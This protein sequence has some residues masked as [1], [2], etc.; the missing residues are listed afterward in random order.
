MMT[1]ATRM[2]QAPM[3]MEYYMFES[4]KFIDQQF[5]EGYAK[6][7][8][9]LLAAFIT[10]SATDFVGGMLHNTLENVLEN[11]MDNRGLEV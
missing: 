6:E 4:I 10:G 3:T 11:M 5:G 8:P 9:V 7:N 1:P 2:R